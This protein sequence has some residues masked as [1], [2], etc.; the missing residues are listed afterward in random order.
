MVQHPTKDLIKNALFGFSN[1][2][3]T[4]N[5]TKLL[6]AI[7]IMLHENA[8]I[9][10]PVA[11][12][13]E[14]AGQIMLQTQKAEDELTYVTAY[15]SKEIFK[16]VVSC[17]TITRPLSN[18]FK[19][20][21][22]MDG[23]AGIIFNPATKYPFT[24]QKTMVKE[25]LIEV[26]NAPLKNSIFVWHGDITTLDCDVIVN[27]ANSTLLG[28]GGV[29]AAIHRGAGSQLLEEC[30]SLGGCATGE[31][32]ITFG[33]NLPASYVIHTVGPIYE[34]KVEQRLELANCYSN[35]LDLAR[36][37]HLHSIAFPAISTGAYGYPLD[38]AARI[39]LLTVTSWLN[40]NSNYG[41]SVILACYTNSTADI[42]KNFI[43]LAREGKLN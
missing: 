7:S 43:S 8:Q 4:L 30:K 29:D 19:A 16:T 41:M 33:Y 12:N 42:Y 1:E 3:N 6:R 39:A 22:L 2:Q 5:R 37:Y 21:L 11:S 14:S 27:A 35:S 15:S 18:Y 25:L 10:I 32:K 23:I 17:P 31:A 34:G 13:K 20:I 38:E 36:Q 26:Q 28:G 24:V 40:I 9:I